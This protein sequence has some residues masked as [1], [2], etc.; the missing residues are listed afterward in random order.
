[1]SALRK[2]AKLFLSTTD[3]SLPGIYN[4]LVGIELAI[5]NEI[6]G[7]G[8]PWDKNIKHNIIPII[9]AEIDSSK[10]SQLYNSLSKL[11]CILL[12]GKIGNISPQKYPD[13]RYFAFQ[14]DDSNGSPEHELEELSEIVED[15]K[16]ISRSKGKYI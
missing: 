15:I 2:N 12:D 10:A 6:L 8:E 5:K 14:E 13:L 3:K 11:K 7:K 9:S 4:N 1:M 16:K